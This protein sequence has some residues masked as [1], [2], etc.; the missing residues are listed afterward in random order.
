MMPQEADRQIQDAEHSKG[1]PTGS[2]NKPMACGEKG[3]WQRLRCN[4][5]FHSLLK[6]VHPAPPNPVADL[7]LSGPSLQEQHPSRPTESR[8]AFACS[9]ISSPEMGSSLTLAPRTKS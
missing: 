3:V 5:R 6:S 9:S 7:F 1:Q 8:R 4:E 2:S